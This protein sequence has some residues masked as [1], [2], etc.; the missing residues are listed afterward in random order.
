MHLKFEH[1]PCPLQ[2][3]GHVRTEQ[4]SPFQPGRHTHLPALQAP[5]YEHSLGHDLTAQS[6]PRQPGWQWH[7]AL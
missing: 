6:A 5:W 2:S 7:V 1:M 3:F 4:S